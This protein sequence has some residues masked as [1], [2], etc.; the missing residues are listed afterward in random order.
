MSSYRYQQGDRPIEGYTIEYALG[1]GGFG[2]VYFALSDAGREVALKVVHQF[3][4]IE[5]RGIRHCMNLKSPHL[6]SIFD[7]R[8]A[9]D[10]TP[11]I[12]MEH[13]AG[14]SL[15]E[16]LDRHPDGLGSAQAL[17]FMRELTRGLTYLHDAGI[18]HRDL[19]PHNI[20]FE[21]GIVKIG[22]YSLSKAISASHRSGHT[23]T[24]GSVHYMAPE[25]GEGRYDQTVD[26]YALGIILYE[27]LTGSPPY[28]GQSM[29]EVLMKHLSGKPDVS[30][31]AEPFAST[32]QKAL[33]RQPDQRF[34]S[35]E[36]ML[37]SL[38]DRSAMESLR[39]PESLSMIGQPPVR[40]GV[41]VAAPPVSPPVA[42]EIE[43]VETVEADLVHDETRVDTGSVPFERPRLPAISGRQP[44]LQWLGLRWSPSTQVLP[45][46]DPA[47]PVVRLVLSAVACF[48]TVPVAASAMGVQMEDVVQLAVL[49]FIS[50][51]MFC[52]T[53]LAVLPRSGG[54]VSGMVTRLV[55]F[56]VLLPLC[57]LVIRF[58][59]HE[60]A[61]WAV[62]A[63]ALTNLVF[64]WRCFLAID[65]R[66]RIGASRTLLL[67]AF[68]CCV[69]VMVGGEFALMA[70]AGIVAGAMVVQLM[71]P[72]RVNR[73][74]RKK[75][76]R[77]NSLRDQTP[78]SNPPPSKG[79]RSQQREKP[80]EESQLEFRLQE[81]P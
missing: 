76:S 44:I 59:S 34:E 53:C 29:G 65:R 55:T 14:D 1:R 62:S 69:G 51:L 74:A 41:G 32:I 8:T 67:G 36:A 6:V 45:D 79:T 7:V 19:K 20:F 42:R 35:A 28:I 10:G 11:W 23:R 37:A 17:Y 63:I 18:V 30:Q 3:E 16:M 64:D 24:V 58:E 66:P 68:A 46:P 39:P 75:R 81:L 38:G 77:A 33:H 2:E 56:A 12:I 43:K 48:V 80:T 13:V 72:I 73:I 61:H 52:W 5:L 9:Q 22:D 31:I 4:E 71:A 27:M 47:P 21:Q 70:A 15:R 60:R 57:F 25:I 49:T 40:R 78:L 26:V 50:A 54:F